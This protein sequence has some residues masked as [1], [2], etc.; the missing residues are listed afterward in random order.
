VAALV[1]AVGFLLR[2][3]LASKTFL[4]GDEALHFMA[5]NQPSWKLTYQA[6]LTISHPPLLIFVLHLWRVFGTSEALVCTSWQASGF[7]ADLLPQ[8]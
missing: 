4:N 6:S 8:W 1:V 2:L 5:A 3:R 7:G